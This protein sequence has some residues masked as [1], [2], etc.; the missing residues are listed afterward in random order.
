MAQQ[1]CL[2]SAKVTLFFDMTKFIE[3]F[4]PKPTTIALMRN[5]LSGTALI[6]NFRIKIIEI[7]KY[8][9][10]IFQQKRC[11]LLPQIV[12]KVQM[13]RYGVNNIYGFLSF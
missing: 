11:H 1:K 4:L 10:E 8:K 7:N 2:L 3:T 12:P 13:R 5:N 9:R 6:Y